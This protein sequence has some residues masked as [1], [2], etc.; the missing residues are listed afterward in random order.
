MVQTVD[1]HSVARSD[2]DYA[3]RSLS[4]ALLVGYACVS[5]LA[6]QTQ[7]EF[8]GATFRYA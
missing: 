2:C 5:C 4:F 7:D 1:F 6:K 8:D 3:D